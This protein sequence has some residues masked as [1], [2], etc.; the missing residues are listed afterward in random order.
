MV[1]GFRRRDLEKRQLQ[2]E[3][4]IEKEKLKLSRSIERKHKI[5]SLKEKA[6]AFSQ[7]DFNLRQRLRRK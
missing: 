1:L 2:R 4:K 6:K 3:E 5:E 7:K